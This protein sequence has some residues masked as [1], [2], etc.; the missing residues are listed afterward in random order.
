[1]LYSCCL[2][3]KGYK[4][5]IICDIQRQSY[6]SIPSTLYEITMDIGKYSIG[7]LKM[8][9]VDE[10]I[11]II[12]LYFRYL[13]E[14][15][16]LFYTPFPSSFPKLDIGDW[17]ESS[18]I[19]NA[20]ID[21]GEDIAYNFK[22]ILHDLNVLGCRQLQIRCYSIKSLSFFDDA[23]E[24]TDSNN[25]DAIELII[26]Y[27]AD[28]ID[29]PIEYL[30][31]KYPLLSRI[32]LFNAPLN[33]QY[34][35]GTGNCLIVYSTQQ[36]DDETHCGAISKDFFSFNI[37]AFTESQNWNSCLNRKISIDKHG[38]IKNCPSM[39]RSYGS[40]V[41]KS[42]L[43]VALSANGFKD[44]WHIKKDDISGCKD[45]EYRYVCSDC[46]AYL[47]EDSMYSK[48][49]KCRYDPYEAIHLE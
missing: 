14:Q 28:I 42:L 29:I 19:T 40:I 49:V 9:Y 48:P 25:L 32:V 26:A 13:W 2:P 17:D 47:D 43:E 46:R 10:D 35:S 5:S 18:V 36:I 8:K 30:T 38:L 4:N 21:I 11:E 22:D 20:I 23:L 1:M 16:Y 41:E 39:K 7:Q 6:I 12:E 34:L 33:N 27:S 15:K 31:N 3:V 45:C 24:N 37:K 44:L